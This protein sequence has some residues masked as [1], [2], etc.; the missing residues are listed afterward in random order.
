[1]LPVLFVALL[2]ALPAKQKQIWRAEI[3]LVVGC[4][5]Q[6]SLV[7]QMCDVLDRQNLSLST[8]GNCI[9]ALQFSS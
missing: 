4:F 3:Q 2:Q 1:M 8:I 9:W 5:V 7:L 6:V